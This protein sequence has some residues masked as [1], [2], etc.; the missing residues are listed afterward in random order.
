MNIF[1]K[2]TDI[3]HIGFVKE[4]SGSIKINTES[5]STFIQLLNCVIKNKHSNPTIDGRWY[6]T[7]M[8]KSDNNNN[9]MKQND[10]TQYTRDL[11]KFGYYDFSIENV[12]IHFEF[13]ALPD[14]Y[15]DLLI[16]C[17]YKD[18]SVHYE[19]ESGKTMTLNCEPNDTIQNIKE[20]IRDEDG[21]HG[22]PPEQI[23][24]IFAGNQLEIGRTLSDYNIQKDS[25]INLVRRLRGS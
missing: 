25:T 16:S 3:G 1:I 8:I 5:D 23:R 2:F 13:I 22:I 10:S 15:G 12:E 24:L 9:E 20:K 7:K 21:N 14:T 4:G 11:N 19:L 18:G 17:I 6:I